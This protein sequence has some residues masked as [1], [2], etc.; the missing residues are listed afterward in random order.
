[1]LPAGSAARAARFSSTGNRSRFS[2][3]IAWPVGL[4]A[5]RRNRRTPER[6][7]RAR[8]ITKIWLVS[9]GLAFRARTARMAVSGC[10][11]VLVAKSAAGMGHL[12]LT[13]LLLQLSTVLSIVRQA[14]GPEAQ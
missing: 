12:L 6:P 8:K 5:K 7:R 13:G 10:R 14:L 4:A 11:R 9:S 1:M 2:R 3:R